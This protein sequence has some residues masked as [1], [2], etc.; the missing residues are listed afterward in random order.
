MQI[1]KD[2]YPDIE[3]LSVSF[4]VN[5]KDMYVTEKVDGIDAPD[6]FQKTIVSSQGQEIPAFTSSSFALVVSE[7]SDGITIPVL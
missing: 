1:P 2:Q 5:G 6:G 7:G 4:L 3:N